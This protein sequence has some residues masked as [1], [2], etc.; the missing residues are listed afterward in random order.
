MNNNM[1][2]DMINLKMEIIDEV[3]RHL[4]SVTKEK[5]DRLE[6]DFMAALNEVSKEYLEKTKNPEKTQQM[7]KVMIE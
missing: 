3:S 2:R 7:K 1:I 5:I 6:Y 4:P